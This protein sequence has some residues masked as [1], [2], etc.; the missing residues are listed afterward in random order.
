MS[1]YSYISEFNPTNVDWKIKI[2]IIRRWTQYSPILGETIELVLCDELGD[3]IHAAIY[4]ELVARF[5]P[6]FREGYSRVITNFVLTPSIGGYRVTRHAYK[7]K[8]LTTTHSSYSEP[9]PPRLTGFQ[10]VD[11]TEIL[12]SEFYTDNLVDVIGQVVGFSNVDIIFVNGKDTIKMSLH[13]MNHVRQRLSI[14]IWAKYA[15]VVSQGLIYNI[16]RLVICV[17]RFGMISVCQSE[18][19]ISNVYNISEIYLNADIDEVQD[20]SEIIAAV[21]IEK[22]WYNMICKDCG[23]EV[24][25][26]PYGF[27][28]GGV[29]EMMSIVNYFCVKC[30]TAVTKPEKR[31]DKNPAA[32]ADTVSGGANFQGLAERA[33]S[34]I[35]RPSYGDLYLQY[36]GRHMVTRTCEAQSGLR[37]GDPDPH[38]LG[39]PYDDLTLQR[40]GCHMAK[41]SSPISGG[42]MATCAS[43]SCSSSSRDRNAFR[44]VSIGVPIYEKFELMLKVNIILKKVFQRKR[45]ML[46]VG[47]TAREA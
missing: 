33:E 46:K 2:K 21:D 5:D 37:Y 23:N 20:F 43:S 26:V 39:S 1:T 13:L 41:L 38:S 44:L 18:R 27:S 17:V 30:K 12:N 14:E 16:N 42:H 35:S 40:P 29:D 19:S 6:Y 22:E 10:P 32:K 28:S 15:E 3:M 8:F 4:K 47:K 9:L 45:K 31:K 36:T 11:F 34:L 25:N 24:S 7:I